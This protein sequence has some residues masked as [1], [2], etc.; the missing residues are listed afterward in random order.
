VDIGPK[1]NAE[2]SKHTLHQREENAEKC[3]PIK[4]DK[5]SFK[6]VGKFIYLGT[7]LTNE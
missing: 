2:K 5:I 4:T 7:A 3:L 6:A 1:L